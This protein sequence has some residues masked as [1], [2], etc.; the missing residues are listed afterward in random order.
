MNNKWN[1]KVDQHAK[2]PIPTDSILLAFLVRN[3]QQCGE[4][5]PQ[6]LNHVKR[7]INTLVWALL[8][9]QFDTDWFLHTAPLNK[10][11]ASF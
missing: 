1:C 10:P 9:E 4:K 8:W 5:N 7:W 3:I 2:I 11:N 6:D